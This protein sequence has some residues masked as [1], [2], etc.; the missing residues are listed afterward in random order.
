MKKLLSLIFMSI[1]ALSLVGCN[2]E[3]EKKEA[4][5]IAN[6]KKSMQNDV[7]FSAARSPYTNPNEKK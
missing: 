1:L 6:Y 5:K 4:E 3:A 7:D 2:S